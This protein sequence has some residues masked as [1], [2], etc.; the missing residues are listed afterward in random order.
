MLVGMLMP[1]ITGSGLYEGP[2]EYSFNDAPPQK[3]NSSARKSGRGSR[4]PPS[5][6]A[7]QLPF[8]DQDETATSARRS[9][10]SNSITDETLERER[11]ISALEHGISSLLLVGT[12]P[13]P[14]APSRTNLTSGKHQRL[15]MSKLSTK[16]DQQSTMVAKL[17][18]QV[19]RLINNVATVKKELKG[20]GQYDE[21]GGVT[22]S[23]QSSKFSNH[24]GF[25]PYLPIPTPV[26]KKT[27]HAGPVGRMRAPSMRLATAP[28]SRTYQD[29]SRF[30]L[31]GL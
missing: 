15:D 24:S 17:Q 6:G 18:G 29:E 25:T 14:S 9:S 28:S 11:R 27:N 20:Q 13:V 22:G 16:I 19:R 8:V 3:R 21:W 12:Q 7:T 5:R 26:G 23:Q 1:H 4:R 10:F 2:V 30:V 31:P